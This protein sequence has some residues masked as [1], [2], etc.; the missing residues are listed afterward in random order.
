MTAADEPQAGGPDGEIRATAGVLRRLGLARV[1]RPRLHGVDLVVA[2]L[3]AVLGFAAVVQ[4]R[5]TQDDGLLASARQEDL[6]AILEGLS[7]RSDRL[8]QEVDDLTLARERLTSGSGQDEAAL[9]E[10]RRRTQVLG[11]LAGT[12]PATGPG[13]VLTLQDAEGGLPAAVLLDA[14]EEL[15][16]AGAEAVQVEG[17]PVRTEGGDVRVP[18][19]R[20]VASTALLDAEGGS[21]GDVTVGGG[22]E[23]GG[24]LLAPPY[25]FRVVGDPGTL[26]SALRIPGGVIDAVAAR[27]GQADVQELDEVTVSALQPFAPPA[28]AR[29][30]P[31][32]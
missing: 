27:G 2:A 22:V 30:A 8:R 6:V 13:V 23:V 5:A 32:G 7:G 31:G 11:V 18:T 3:L 19:V 4:V 10:A 26:A 17:A 14:L 24:T 21:S 15:R 9:E 1:L 29:P 20:V 28:Y 12:V 16:D 25:I